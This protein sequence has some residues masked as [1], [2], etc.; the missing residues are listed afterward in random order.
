MIYLQAN[1]LRSEPL[2][3][4]HVKRRLLGHWGSSPGLSFAYIPLNRLITKYDLDA[5]FLAGPGPSSRA[6]R[7]TAHTH[8]RTVC[9]GDKGM[10]V[11]S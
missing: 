10:E 5:I 11:T 4:E 2:Q 3:P 6:S 9:L 7:Q 1:P 8:G